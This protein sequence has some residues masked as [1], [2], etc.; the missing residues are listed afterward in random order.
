MLAALSGPLAGAVFCVLLWTRW[1]LA[2]EMSLVLTAVNLLPV[3]PLDGGRALAC[4]LHRCRR[5]TDLMGTVRLAVLMLLLACGVCCAAAG[6]GFAPL[7]FVFWLLL[8]PS[9]SCKTKLNDVQ[10]SY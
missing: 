1:T 7:L 10:Y 8:T 4:A 2:A 9:R 5:G 3:L 6:W